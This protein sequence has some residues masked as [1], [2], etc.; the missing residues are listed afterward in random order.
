MKPHV[1][2]HPAV[3]LLIVLGSDLLK[4]RRLDRGERGV[5]LKRTRWA[6]PRHERWH[7]VVTMKGDGS[8]FNRLV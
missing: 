4:A 2:R 1:V 7:G 8:A 5:F 3:L 6:G